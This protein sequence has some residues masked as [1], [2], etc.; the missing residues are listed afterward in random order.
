MFLPRL[1]LQ[2]LFCSS[3]TIQ[4]MFFIAGDFLGRREE[5]VAMAPRGGLELTGIY[6]G[7]DFFLGFQ[8]FFHERPKI[9]GHAQTPGVSE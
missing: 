8:F 6:G 9:G 1:A 5:N 3:I 7:S 4:R 2:D